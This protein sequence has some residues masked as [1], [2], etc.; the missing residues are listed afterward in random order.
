MTA[1]HERRHQEG[2]STSSDYEREA[3]QTRRRLA[4]HLDE[5]SDRLTPGQVFDEMLTYSRAGGG[6]F[7]TAF[8]NAMRQNPL[9][10]LLIGAGCMMFLS[11]KM[12]LRP[13]NGSR[14]TVA[15]ADDPYGT[16]AGASYPSDLTARMSEASDRVP[17]ASG[18]ASDAAASMSDAAGRV[19]GAAA[20]SA[21]SAAASVQSGFSTVTESASRQTSNAAGAVADTMRQTTAA[22]GGT[23]T[24]AAD[25]VRSTARGMRDQTSAAT[26]QALRNARSMAGA[27]RDTAASMSGEMADTASS[28]G[29]AIADTAGRT[30]RQA[31]RAVRQGR[32]NA[33]MLVN[34]QPLLAASIGVAIGAAL[35]ILLPP[36]ETEDQLMGEA[37]D[38]VKGRASQV[39]SDALESAKHVA[40]KVADRA[41]TAAAEAVR[42]EGL[43]PS[44]VAEAARN[45]GE[46]IRDGAQ[47]AGGEAARKVGEGVRQGTQSAMKQP[48]TGTGPQQGA[49]GSG[50]S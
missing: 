43:S 47:G 36:T 6:T 45:I 28:M 18:R 7:F 31:T 19:T 48:V 27:M 24:G 16:G 32:D 40:S 20:S 30:R 33:A 37:S 35:A 5:L 15:S 49:S 50:R 4:D 39:G 1:H 34:E 29:D 2:L 13:G 25:A 21:R 22:V 41:Q 12:G 9:P 8:S 44:A 11:E 38:A 17:R 3:E 46:G 10:S 23:V 26:D 42:E 14:P